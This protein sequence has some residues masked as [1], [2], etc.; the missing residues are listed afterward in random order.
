MSINY[1]AVFKVTT[2]N[3]STF[4]CVKHAITIARVAG[5]LG[6]QYE[7]DTLDDDDLHECENCV[8]ESKAKLNKDSK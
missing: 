6:S 3:G 1:P 4:A 2:S 5:I 8:N 7:Q